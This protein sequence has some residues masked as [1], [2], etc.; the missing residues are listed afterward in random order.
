[1]KVLSRCESCLVGGCFIRSNPQQERLSLSPSL[2]LPLPLLSPS[3]S[4]SLSASPSLSPSP[5]HLSCD[6]DAER[7]R[8]HKARISTIA[9]GRIG[10]LMRF[11]SLVL[12]RSRCEDSTAPQDTDFNDCVHVY[13]SKGLDPDAETARLRKTRISTIA[14]TSI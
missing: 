2:Y 3:L 8:L 14:C 10:I 12:V 4:L 1:M 9:S 11:V 6:F 7:A 5:S 13:L